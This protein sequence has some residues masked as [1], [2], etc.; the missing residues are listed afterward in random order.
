VIAFEVAKALLEKF[1]G[2]SLSEVRQNYDTFLAAARQ[3]PLPT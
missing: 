1:G 3:L 2:D